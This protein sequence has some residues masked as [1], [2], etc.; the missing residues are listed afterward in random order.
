MPRCPG[1]AV[2]VFAAPRD[3]VDGLLRRLEVVGLDVLRL[4]TPACVLAP[5]IRR[6]ARGERHLLFGTADDATSF[7][8]VEDGHVLMERILPWGYQ[9]LVKR[10][11]DELEL[12]EGNSRRLLTGGHT[13]AQASD[14]SANPGP[15][16]T[17]I[18]KSLRQVLEADFKELTSQ[19][20]SCLS[21]CDSFFRPAEIVAAT[22]VGPL[23]DCPFLLDA[24]AED[25]GLPVRG[26]DEGLELPGLAAGK[27]QAA[28]ATPACCALWSEGGAA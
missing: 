7:A 24:L 12:D 23:A 9:G 21:Y 28:F 5:R 10:L 26:P 4:L 3:L 6:E 20:A 16:D 18:V 15:P 14:D 19:A 13:A 27:G 2:L 1:T 25:L 11:Q 8:V 22:I 17:S